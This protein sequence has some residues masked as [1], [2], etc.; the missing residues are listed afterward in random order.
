MAQHQHRLGAQRAQLHTRRRVAGVDDEG[1]IHP[2]SGDALDEV[3]GPRIT[4]PHLHARVGRAERGQFSRDIDRTEARLRTD[5][6]AAAHESANGGHCVACGGRTRE[7]THGV[8]EERLPSGRQLHSTR[9]ADEQGRAQF[10][11]ERANG[12][13]QSRLR[14]LEEFG[15]TGEVPLLCD[16]DEML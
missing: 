6:E 13:G 5:R 1:D 8:A 11:L 4:Q 9:A 3:D 7:G 2:P 16:G 10:L 12:C 14:D 15:G